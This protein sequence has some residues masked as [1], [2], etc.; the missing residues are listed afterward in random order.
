MYAVTAAKA[1]QQETALE[2]TGEQIEKVKEIQGK[3]RRMNRI[4]RIEQA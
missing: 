4:R 1:I 2:V 3:S